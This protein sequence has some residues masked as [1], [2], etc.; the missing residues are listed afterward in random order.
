MNLKKNLGTKIAACIAS[1]GAL[2]A[3]WGLVYQ[4]P[5]PPAASAQAE[6]SPAAA[7]PTVTQRK[8]A[9]AATPVTTQ[10]HTRTRVS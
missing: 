10:R 3:V 2:A 5:P 8:A 1:I 6:T 7:T 9:P 4:N